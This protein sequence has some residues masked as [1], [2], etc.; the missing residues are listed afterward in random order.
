MDGNAR[1]TSLMQSTEEELAQPPPADLTAVEKLIAA[2]ARLCALRSFASSRLD[3]HFFTKL[4]R[5]GETMNTALG[6]TEA[7]RRIDFM[8]HFLAHLGTELG[9]AFPG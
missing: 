8:K 3:D 6:K 5:L 2:D 9:H 4:L 7:N 1:F